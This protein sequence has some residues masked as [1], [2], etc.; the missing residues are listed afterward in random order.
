MR[1]CSRTFQLP[2]PQP[3]LLPGTLHPASTHSTCSQLPSQAPTTTP[4]TLEAT[5]TRDPP[6]AHVHLLALLRDNTAVNTDPVHAPSFLPCSQRT[7]PLLCIP[8][9]LVGSSVLLPETE[10]TVLAP[11]DAGQTRKTLMGRHPLCP[12]EIAQ[13]VCTEPGAFSPLQFYPPLWKA[14]GIWVGNCDSNMRL[15][16][17]GPRPYGGTAIRSLVVFCFVLFFPIGLVR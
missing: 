16:V 5:N 4:C 11:G 1:C 15:G 2:P 13:G 8:T 3:G 10:S 9:P 17:A 14:N 12:R 6:P 7:A